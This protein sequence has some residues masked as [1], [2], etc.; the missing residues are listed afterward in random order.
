MRILI[1][2]THLIFHLG[3][4][5]NYGFLG[6]PAPMKNY[7]EHIVNLSCLPDVHQKNRG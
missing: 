4:R 3:Q 6:G 5:C 1:T 7:A 2:D